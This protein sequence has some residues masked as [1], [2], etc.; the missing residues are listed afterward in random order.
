MLGKINRQA[1]S[2]ESVTCLLCIFNYSYENSQELMYLVDNISLLGMI[3]GN[4][5]NQFRRF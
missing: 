4:V 2:V 3:T 5:Q 1:A